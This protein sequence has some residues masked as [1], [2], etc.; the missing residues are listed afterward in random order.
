MIIWMIVT[1]L[2][3]QESKK[4]VEKIKNKNKKRLFV[5]QKS[6]KYIYICTVDDTTWDK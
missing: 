2:V 4:K 6:S 5:P 3:G 1:T